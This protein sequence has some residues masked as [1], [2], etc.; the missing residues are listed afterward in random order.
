M[1][2]RELPIEGAYLIEL[3]KLGDE[4]GFFARLFCRREFEELGLATE[5]V[6]LNNSFN[7][8]PLT[9]RGMHYQAP[10]YAET[11]MVRCFR[12][13]LYDVVL[14]LRRDSPT[15]GRSVGVELSGEGREMVY[16]PK[17]TAHGFLTLE[18]DTE[19][20]YLMDEFYQPDAQRGVRWDDPAFDIEWPERPEVISDRDR[21]YPD[22]DDSQAVV[23]G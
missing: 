6:Q 7:A 17:G 20:L 4:R 11:K 12:G 3:E 22:F 2:V 21:S 23:L 5:L 10:P 19:I 13:R 16:A 1:I 9:L 8:T 15:F 18:P 14:D